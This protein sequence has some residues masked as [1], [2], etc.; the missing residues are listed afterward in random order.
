M[1]NWI[2]IEERLPEAWE[3]VMI[4]DGYDIFTGRISKRRNGALS[5]T[6]ITGHTNNNGATHWM[7]LPEPP[8]NT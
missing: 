4:Y 1:S 2:P 8:K 3:N 6:Y 7:P 5:V